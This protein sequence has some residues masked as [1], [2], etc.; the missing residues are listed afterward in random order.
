MPLH[1]ELGCGEKLTQLVALVELRGFLD[2]V[3]E[4]RGKLKVRRVLSGSR[5]EVLHLTADVLEHS[6]VEKTGPIGPLTGAKNDPAR[7]SRVRGP[8]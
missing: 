1:V 4:R 8:P 7:F 5:L 3:D 6:I 2:L